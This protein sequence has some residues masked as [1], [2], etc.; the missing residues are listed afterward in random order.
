MLSVWGPLDACAVAARA[1]NQ[2]LHVLALLVKFIQRKHIF[3]YCDPIGLFES[4]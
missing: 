2:V 4:R 3:V 1:F